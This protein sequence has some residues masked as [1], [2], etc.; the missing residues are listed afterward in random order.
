MAGW[1]AYLFCACTLLLV[2]YYML[3]YHV[4][5]VVLPSIIVKRLANLVHPQK[6]IEVLCALK[7]IVKCG[8]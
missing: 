1:L 6:F 4:I 3:H 5:S 7:C 8:N 2:C